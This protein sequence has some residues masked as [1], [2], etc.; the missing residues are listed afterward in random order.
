MKT[1]L[2]FPYPPPHQIFFNSAWILPPLL[3]NSF[4]NLHPWQTRWYRHT[5]AFGREKYSILSVQQDSRY[6][7][8]RQKQITHPR[9]LLVKYLFNSQK[10][11]D[12]LSSTAE[13]AAQ[14]DS[15]DRLN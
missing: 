3:P 14:T 11:A 6:S 4:A 8:A 12:E 9:I 5:G 2:E 1:Y 7:D 15:K 10:A 13:D